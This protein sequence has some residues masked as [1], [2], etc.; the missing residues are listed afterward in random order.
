MQVLLTFS[1]EI[2]AA[3][4]ERRIVSGL[5]APY[6]EI[7]HTSAGAVMFERGSIAIPDATAI[8]LLMQ[9]QNDKPVGRAISFS[10][11]TEGV[12]G[13]FKLSSSTRGQ[14]ALVL[15]QE[16]LVSGLSVGVD[17]TASKP[18][19][20]YLLVTEAV[21]REV[22]LVES[23]AFSSASV[24]EIAAARA[25]LIAATSTKEKTTTINTTIVEIETETETESEEAVTT[26]PE[27]T[28]DDTPVDAPAEAEKVEAAR[29]IIRPSVLDSQKLRTPINSMA[30]YTEHK[31]KAALGSDDSRLYVTAA[32][33]SFTT[34]PAFNPTQY[35]SEF[36]SN[37]NFDTPMIN[38]LSQGALPATGNTIQVPSLVTSAGGGSGVAPVVTFEAEA[39]AVQNTGMVTEYLSG[40]VKKYAGMNTLSVELLERA[41]DPNFYAE[42]TNQLQRA[43]SLA[44]DAAVI[45]D[46]VA[47]G[48]QGTAVAATSAGIISYVSTESANIY[49]NTSYFA[50]NY[51]AGPSQWSLLMGATDTTGRPIY[52]AA[53]PMNS[54]GLSTPTSI[55]GNVL[56]LDLYVDH[57]MVSTTIDDSAF[58][59][60]PEA[61]TVY[62]SPQAYMSVNVVSNLQVQVA[63]YGFMATIVKMPNGLVRY[64]LT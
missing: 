19:G 44:T 4:T 6:G 14:D 48:V 10:D 58:I 61:M 25:E 21:L 63:I 57:Q 16:N 20:D 55:R 42:L 41:Q 47:G 62:R 54:G 2:Q 43:Y 22:S 39:G 53:A 37:T 5:V 49:K 7:G 26:A 30:T 59:V 46:V 32:D 35:L 11:S 15:A 3:D 28:P 1:Q 13:S 29:K 27:N 9:H 45:A 36:V 8:K 50:K 64:N 33:D 24:T 51:V 52:N 56:G 12:Y 60:A 38:A 40:T 34:N 18:M 31:I 17:V 23:A